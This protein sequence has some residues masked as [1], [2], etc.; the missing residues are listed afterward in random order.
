MNKLI[1]TVLVVSL[2]GCFFV[3]KKPAS[4]SSSQSSTG[5]PKN[6]GQQRADEVHERNEERKEDK[7]AAKDNK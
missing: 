5:E 4:N 6:H 1:I 3:K 2:S 7:D